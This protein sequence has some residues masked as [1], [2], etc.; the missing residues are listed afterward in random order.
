MLPNARV[1]PTYYRADDSFSHCKPGP[2]VGDVAAT[3]ADVMRMIEMLPL[4][5]HL[6][7]YLLVRDA[8]APD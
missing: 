7:K 6:G 4:Q 5:H 1:S 8:A 3:R 2:L